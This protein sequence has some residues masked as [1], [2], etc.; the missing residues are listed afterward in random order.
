MGQTKPKSQGPIGQASLAL[1][2]RMPEMATPVVPEEMSDT[3]KKILGAIE[4]S[5]LTLQRDIGK[6]AAEL[7]LLRADHQNLSDKLRE[8]ESTVTNIQPSHQALK[9]QV[10]HLTGAWNGGQTMQRDAAVATMSALSDCWK[11]WRNMLEFLEPWLHAL[12]DS[13]Q[14][15]PFFALERAHRVPAQRP[16]PGRLPRPVVAK[17]LHYRDRDL[18]LQRARMAGPFKVKGGQASLFLDFTEAVQARRD[19]FT[20]VKRALREEGV[21]YGLLFPSWLKLMVAGTVHFCQD[22]K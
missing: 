10:P 3:L 13:N 12:M 21:T 8:V 4:D 6:V 2:D 5:K 11:E 19:S 22:P 15:M 16:Q 14:L 7:G 20:T 18:L 1:H 9:L 17:L